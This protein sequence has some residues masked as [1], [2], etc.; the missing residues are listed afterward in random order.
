M[1]SSPNLHVNPE[2]LALVAVVRW[3]PPMPC[4]RAAIGS[5]VPDT[6]VSR[7]SSYLLTGLGSSESMLLDARNMP[8]FGNT[9]S[10]HDT[11]LPYMVRL[12]LAPPMADDIVGF[13]L[14][15]RELRILHT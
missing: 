9:Y 13:I 2:G 8:K 1:P 11:F 10:S 4:R 14:P 3:V 6:S 5:V 7:L 12:I 15:T